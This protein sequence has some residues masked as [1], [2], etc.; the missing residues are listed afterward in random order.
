ME[1]NSLRNTCGR[2]AGPL[3]DPLSRCTACVR[4]GEAKEEKGGGR[5]KEEGGGR[6][7]EGGRRAKEEGENIHLR[8]SNSSSLDR[9]KN[10]GKKSLFFSK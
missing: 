2:G 9:K 1:E 8:I 7:K 6:T 10:L 4:P 5:A 3:V